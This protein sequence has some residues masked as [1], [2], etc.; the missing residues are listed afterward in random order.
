MRSGKASRNTNQERK[1]LKMKSVHVR[2]HVKE[3][4]KETHYIGHI[5]VDGIQIDFELSFVV[6][7]SRIASMD[8][9]EIIGKIG[10][11]FDLK[12]SKNGKNVNLAEQ[13]SCFL[14]VVC[15]KIVT[16]ARTASS[17]I[18]AR[19]NGHNPIALEGILK[20]GEHLF[21]PAERRLFN[22]VF[23]CKLPD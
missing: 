4:K 3:L 11:L 15:Y 20:V 14:G 6:P 12:M 1:L 22:K 16:Q 13:E 5:V 10:K 7:I 18:K 23:G 17:A 2:K 21:T 9:A 19:S 8:D